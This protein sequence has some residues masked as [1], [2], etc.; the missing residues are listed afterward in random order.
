MRHVDLPFATWAPRS[1]AKHSGLTTRFGSP[2]EVAG[3]ACECGKVLGHAERST[4][5]VPTIPAV[6]ELDYPGSWRSVTVGMRV[7]LEPGFVNA[8]KRHP[9]GVKRWFV[10]GPSPS[11]PAPYVRL[12]AVVTCACGIDS[13]I[14]ADRE[15][16]LWSP[17]P[18]DRRD[19]TLQG[20]LEDEAEDHAHDD[21]EGR[22]PDEE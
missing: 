6:P 20:M 4:L 16:S 11:K 22:E 15:A 21:W 12:P 9:S 7:T 19:D 8:T 10:R 14:P 2:S 17:M 18:A 5:D 1:P 3:I 13:L